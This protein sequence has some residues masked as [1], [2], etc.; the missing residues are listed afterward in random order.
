MHL[1][2]ISKITL[3]VHGTNSSI[4]ANFAKESVHAPA[5]FEY[6]Y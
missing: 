4:F 5:H 2:H 6:V 1:I 3:K